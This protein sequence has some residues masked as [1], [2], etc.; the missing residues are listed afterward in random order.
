MNKDD[1]NNVPDT[2]IIGITAFEWLFYSSQ[3]DPHVTVFGAAL[4][5]ED[6]QS[7][8]LKIAIQSQ[9]EKNSET[10]LTLTW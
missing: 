7:K 2:Q 6:F 1:G 4:F 9:S 5:D 3:L 8:R 10:D